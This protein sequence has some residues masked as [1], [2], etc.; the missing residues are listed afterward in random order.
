MDAIR[1]FVGHDER[2]AIGLSIFIQSLIRHA[3]RPVDLTII[4]AAMAAKLGV[5]TDGTNA[6]TKSRFLV[7]FWCGYCGPALWLDGADMLLRADV[8]E[9]MEL[10]DFRSAVQVV[11]H[12]YAPKAARKYIGTA[13]EAPNVPYERKN[14]S[15]VMLM[16]CDSHACRRLTPDYVAKHNGQHLH[17]MEW[18]EDRLGELPAEWNWLDEYGENPEAKLVHYTNGIPA[19]PHYRDAPHADEWRAEREAMLAFEG[20]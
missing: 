10:A 12:D 16:W 17:R 2:E 14:W 15:S 8:C 6:F 5:G 13:M 19:F 9:L 7:P 4:T 3:S 11:Q 20:A 1:L 18:G